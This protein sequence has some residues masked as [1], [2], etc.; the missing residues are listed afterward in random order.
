MTLEELK[1]ARLNKGL[2]LRQAAEQIGVS[3]E[4]LRQI[5][6]GSRPTPGVGKLIADF[7]EVRFTD[8]WPVEERAA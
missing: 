5:E 8:I 6:L 1:A 4:T 7:Y 2:N 3:T